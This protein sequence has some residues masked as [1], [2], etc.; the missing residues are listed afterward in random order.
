[1]QSYQFS[2]FTYNPD[3]RELSWQKDPSGNR[4][5]GSQYLRKKVADVLLYLLEKRERVVSKDELLQSIWQQGEFRENSLLQSI[6]ELRKLFAESAQSP[7][8]IRT[9]HLKGYQWIYPQVA[10]I[11]PVTEKTEL[12]GTSAEQSENQQ[13][14]A[15]KQIS[16]AE[17]SLSPLPGRQNKLGLKTKVTAFLALTFVLFIAVF[18]WPTKDSPQMSL[19]AGKAE[20]AVL[21]FINDTGD[22]KLQWLELGYSDMFAQGL[23]KFIPLQVIP[24][25]HLQGAMAI[26]Q[27]DKRLSDSEQIS[28]LLDSIN[29]K[30]AIAAT[31]NKDGKALRFNYRIHDLKGVFASGSIR[32]PNLPSSLP[33]LISQVAQHLST[34]QSPDGKAALALFKNK[35]AQQDYAKGTQAL[36]TKGAKLAKHYFE[37]ALLNEPGNLAATV[38]LADT[39]SLLAEFEQAQTYY[40]QLLAAPALSQDAFLGSSVYLGLAKLLI[41]QHRLDEVEA[42]L[43]QGLALTKDKSLRYQRAQLIRSKAKYFQLLGDNKQR[44]ALLGQADELSRPFTSLQNEADA[45]YYLGSPTN[46]GLETDP[47]I[48]LRQNQPKLEQAL[49][50]Y[51]ELG[52]KRG[53]ALTL[54]AIGQNYYFDVKKRLEALEQAKALFIQTGNRLDLIDTLNYFGYFFI[55]YHKGDLARQALE[56]AI[57]LLDPLNDPHRAQ[58]SYFFYAFS[59]LDQGIN[60]E[61][62]RAKA[63][64]ASAI[65]GFKSNIEKYAAISSDSITA[66]SHLLLAWAY[67]ESGLS[68]QAIEHIE[69]ALETYQQQGYPVSIRYAQV[70]LLDEYIK[71]QQWQKVVSLAAN[72]TDSY[73]ANIYLARAYYELDNLSQAHQTLMLTKTRF[74]NRWSLADEKRLS[75]YHQGLKNEGKFKLEKI[76]LGEEMSSH[77]NYCDDLWNTEN[78]D[79]VIQLTTSAHQK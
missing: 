73:L 77:Q 45:L 36:Q 18:L 71:Q 69:L 3:T 17:A 4:E 42:L 26:R 29:A 66:D 48:N 23:R 33:S 22:S 38:K 1:M 32:F 15:K 56:Q 60:N 7:K 70:S 11:S 72:V 44:H 54:L 6:R 52:N 19:A 76:I 10:L 25:Y 35:E 20:V 13:Q 9:V 63:F 41:Q 67:S 37:A 53:E 78:I 49:K 31:I 51:R 2:I 64:L 40:R 27:L 74:S 39:L 50:Y 8:F 30:Y 46:I 79:S 68:S 61:G 5:S 62:S 58:R 28:G 47:D 57:P 65:K 24:S 16:T 55:Q 34:N 43:G 59:A 12:T 21:P 75:L 14:A